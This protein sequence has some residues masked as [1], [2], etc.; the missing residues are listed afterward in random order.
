MPPDL[1]HPGRE[2]RGVP[3]VVALVIL[4]METGNGSQSCSPFLY[5]VVMECGAV[6]ERDFV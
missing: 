5:V 3:G 1:P 4:S 6:R 2:D